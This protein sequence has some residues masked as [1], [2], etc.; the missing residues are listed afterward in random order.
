MSNKRVQSSSLVETIVKTKAKP[1]GFVM[2][3]IENLSISQSY[4]TEQIS[5]VG[6]DVP[7]SNVLHGVT[8][9]QISWG[10]AYTAKAED[11]V[12]LGVAPG[13]LNI[14]AHEHISVI[15]NDLETGDLIAEAVD[16]LPSSIGINAGA[17]STLRESFS[18]TARFVRWGSDAEPA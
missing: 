16:A 14:A 12:A 6:H 1:D 3:I 9:A 17:M 11:L 10:R 4:A 18:G 15:F 13:V 5:G 7:Q 2:G 8:G